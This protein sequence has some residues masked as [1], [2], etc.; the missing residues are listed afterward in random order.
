MGNK[1]DPINIVMIGN[2]K[3]GKSNLMGDQPDH[4]ITTDVN[5]RNFE[6]AKLNVTIIDTPGCREFIKNTITGILQVTFIQMEK[7]INLISTLIFG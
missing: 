1:K 3:S 5:H 4:G 6:T 2:F 7:K